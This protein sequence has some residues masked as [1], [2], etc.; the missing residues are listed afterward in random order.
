MSIVTNSAQE[1]GVMIDVVTANKLE[2]ASTTHG[3]NLCRDCLQILR[4][5]FGW[6][7]ALYVSEKGHIYPAQIVKIELDG[8][9]KYSWDYAWTKNALC[10]AAERLRLLGQT[11]WFLCSNDVLHDDNNFVRYLVEH[12]S[13]L[14]NT[15]LDKRVLPKHALAHAVML[16]KLNREDEK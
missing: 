4:E 16:Y 9:Y 14:L 7:H 2:E 6:L 5:R 11:A 1:V 15:P 3:F 8:S 10:S 13:S 12:D